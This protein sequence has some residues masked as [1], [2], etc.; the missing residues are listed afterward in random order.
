VRKINIQRIQSFHVSLVIVTHMMGLW[1]FYTVQ[2]NLFLR[3]FGKDCSLHL[4]VKGR[5]THR[6]EQYKTEEERRAFF[7]REKCL[8]CLTL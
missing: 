1:V 3:L 5:K 6:T 4:Q 7:E 8:K 2:Y